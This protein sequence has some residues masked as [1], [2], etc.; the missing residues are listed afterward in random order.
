MKLSSVAMVAVIGMSGA[1]C[2]ADSGQQFLSEL[3]GSYHSSSGFVGTLV[4]GTVAAESGTSCQT[5]QSLVISTSSPDVGSITYSFSCS[6]GFQG[7]VQGDDFNP[8]AG[9]YVNG[10]NTISSQF[11]STAG[12]VTGIE[13]DQ[14][15]TW[16][17]G[18]MVSYQHQNIYITSLSLT[19]AGKKTV[20]FELRNDQTNQNNDSVTVYHLELI[21]D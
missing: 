11:L 18:N 13:R 7:Q 21:Q 2:L 19:A 16:G 3:S 15:T 12:T 1:T 5:S 6:D 10:Y 4:Q 14:L 8:A 20:T 17:F 9:S